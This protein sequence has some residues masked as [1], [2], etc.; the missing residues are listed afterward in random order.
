MIKGVPRQR[1]YTLA[2]IGENYKSVGD[3]RRF[4]KEI[5]TLVMGVVEA[6]HDED[7]SRVFVV[8]G[9]DKVKRNI[10][11]EASLMHMIE[12]QLRHRGEINCMFWQQ[13]IDPPITAY[14]QP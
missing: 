7:L 12:E 10:M 8:E 2:S 1:D 3:L 9:R 13:N 11:M 6:L 5:D 4:E 14:G